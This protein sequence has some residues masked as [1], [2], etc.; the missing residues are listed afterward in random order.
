MRALLVV[1]AMLWLGEYLVLTRL[2]CTGDRVLAPREIVAELAD[3]LTTQGARLGDPHRDPVDGPGLP[4]THLAVEGV[5]LDA[6]NGWPVRST[7]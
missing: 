5:A 4:C 2:A 7:S 3:D 6:R 1:W